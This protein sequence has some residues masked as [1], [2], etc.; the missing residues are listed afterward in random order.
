MLR[1]VVLCGDALWCV[2][3]LVQWCVALCRV[4]FRVMFRALCCGVL[5][6]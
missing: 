3:L 2:K 5:V 4:V 6:L 1:C